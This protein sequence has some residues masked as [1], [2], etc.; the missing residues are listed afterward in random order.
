M[1]NKA[2]GIDFGGTSVKPGVVAG[3]EIIELA[4]RIP[5]QQHPGADALLEAVMAAIVALREKYPEVCAIGAGLPGMIDSVNGRVHELSNVPGWKDVGL[6]GL[7]E[8]RTG[9]PAAIDNDANAATYA[10]WRY[11]AGRDGVNVIC[12]TLGTGVGGGLI[13]DGKLYRG[14]QLGAGEIGQ[15]TIDPHGVA[16][17]Y[18]NFGALEKY[19]GNSQIAQR[20]Q[21]LYYEDGLTKSEAECSPIALQTAADGGDAI[22]RRVWEEVGFHLGTTLCDIV[23]LLNPDLIVIGGGV[24]KAGEYVFGPIRKTIRERTMKIFHEKLEIVPA[25]LGNDAGIIGSAA[26]ALERAASESF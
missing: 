2:I 6:T 22:A 12:I 14:S 15:M 10:E 8:E 17:H 18:G 16:G 20:A 25:A 19:V 5:T 13:L 1:N 4:E 3:G 23:W 11:G 24:A 9:L 21:L 7:L 26:L